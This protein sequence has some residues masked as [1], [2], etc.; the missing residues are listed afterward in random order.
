MSP[1][2]NPLDSDFDVAS[3][4]LSEGLKTCRSVVQNYRMMLGA[5]NGDISPFDLDSDAT[6]TAANDL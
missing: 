1:E 5:E 6:E 3:T 2:D 4:Q